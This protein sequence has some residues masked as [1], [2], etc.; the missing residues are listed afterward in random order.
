MEK[1]APVFP[2]VDIINRQK[3]RA[4]RVLRL[5]RETLSQVRGGDA[6]YG[7]PKTTDCPVL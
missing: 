5:N 6:R 1:K 2:R 7:L 3:E 4:S